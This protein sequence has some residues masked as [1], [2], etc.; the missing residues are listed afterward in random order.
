MSQGGQGGRDTQ[1]IQDL[2]VAGPVPQ[3][4]IVAGAVARRGV[5]I[6]LAMAYKPLDRL[7]RGIFEFLACILLVPRAILPIYPF[8][9]IDAFSIS[10][11]AAW[12]LFEIV[13]IT[14]FMLVLAVIGSAA[15]EIAQDE[16]GLPSSVGAGTCLDSW[17]F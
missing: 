9:T 1:R 11:L 3:S 16:W 5:Y 10:S 17:W 4:V 8:T 12:F 2:P 6:S 7:L 13:L 14:M 15:G